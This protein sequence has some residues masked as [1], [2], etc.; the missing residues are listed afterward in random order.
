MPNLN[1]S[2]N[3]YT[4]LE[5]MVIYF[6]NGPI[7]PKGPNGVTMETLLAIV[8]DRL[9]CLQ[10]GNFPCFFNAEALD[11]VQK[12]IDSLNARTARVNV[13]PEQP[14]I[15]PLPVEPNQYQLS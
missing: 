7:G 9:T 2:Y 10:D 6:Q 3:S 4:S 11:H 15:K 8:A 14:T 5:G 13:T 1:P 12:A